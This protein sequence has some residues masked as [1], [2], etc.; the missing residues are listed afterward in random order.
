[1]SSKPALPNVVA[2]DEYDKEHMPISFFGKPTIPN[3]TDRF[4][5]KALL[6]KAVPAG[7]LNVLPWPWASSARPSISMSAALIICSRTMKMRS[8]NRKLSP[9]RD[10]SD[11]G[12]TRNIFSVEH[13]KM[14]KS[15][16]NFFT[17]RDLLRKGL[18]RRSS[19]LSSLTDALPHSAQFFVCRPRCCREI[20]RAFRR[21][22]ST[23]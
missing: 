14:S 12:S 10:L 9:T 13:K 19:P 8:L 4:F 21:L 17:L 6:E 23:A 5:G 20:N 1:M 7:I 18:Y 11:T 22:Y 16:G 2:T 15:L 3:A